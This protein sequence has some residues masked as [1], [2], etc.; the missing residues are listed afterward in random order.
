MDHEH[1]IRRM[2]RAIICEQDAQGQVAFDPADPN[3]SLTRD[4]K[5]VR[6]TDYY[7]LRQAVKGLNLKDLVSDL[8]KSAG[9]DKGEEGSVPAIFESLPPGLYI[10]SDYDSPRPGDRLHKGIDIAGANIADKNVVAALPGD[11]EVADSN[12]STGFGHQVVISHPGGLKTRY[13]HLDNVNVNVRGSVVKGDV[14]G[15]VGNT[16]YVE[17]SP[18]GTGHHLHFSLYKNGSPIN[19]MTASNEL[20]DAVFPVKMQ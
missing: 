13:A 14:I 16:G 19:P 15:T 5:V 10:S 18:G 4:G 6:V 17:K 11:V 2:I 9:D 1:Q 12:T 20:K 7:A 3:L 8:E